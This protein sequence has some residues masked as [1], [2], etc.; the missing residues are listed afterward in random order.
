MTKKSFSWKRM[1]LLIAI[2]AGTMSTMAVA[3]EKGDKAVGGKLA[4]GAGDSYTNLGL[5]A[6][7]RYNV[8]AP[9]R[10]EG[11]FTYFLPK[12]HMSMW[13]SGVDAHWLF[14]AGDRLTVYPLA[15]L[16]ILGWRYSYDIDWLGSSASNSDFTF[17]LGGGVDFKLTNR[18]FLNAELKYKITD[19]WDRLL[20][21]A[22]I[23]CKF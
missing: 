8:T 17:D 10:L 23:V 18:L 12:D 21:S 14:S 15:G 4:L 19:Y 7:F 1:P 2:A 22:G 3:Q 20:L 11:S 16:G 13:D 6:R 5:G 9:L